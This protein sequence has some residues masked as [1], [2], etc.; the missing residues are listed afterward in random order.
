MWFLVAVMLLSHFNS[1]KMPRLDF[2]CRC[3]CLFYCCRQAKYEFEIVAN[4]WRHGTT[5]VDFQVYFAIV[6]FDEASDVFNYVCSL[7]VVVANCNEEPGCCR[8]IVCHS[9]LYWKCL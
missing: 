7:T 3:F 4:S 5:F 1:K 2:L 6:D 9:L 8:G